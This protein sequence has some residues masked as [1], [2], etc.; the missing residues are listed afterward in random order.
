MNV[1][2][3]IEPDTGPATPVGLTTATARTLLAPLEGTG[4]RA[5]LV[6]GRLGTA[7]RLGLLIDGERLPSE[8]Q[9]AAQLGVSTVTLREA[10]STLRE[11]G[12]VVTRRGRSGGTFVQAPA[13]PGEPIGRFSVHDLQDLGDQ[14]R[15]IAGM[16]ARLAAERAQPEEVLRIAEQVK[17]L[18]AAETASDRRRADTQLAI[19]IAAAAQSPRLTHEEARLRAEIGDLLGLAIDRRDHE[20]AVRE[21]SRLVDALRDR[22]PE[23]ARELAE[24][25]VEAETARLIDLRLQLWGPGRAGSGRRSADD[26]LG[27]V[28]E[29]LE[30]IFD[31]LA[32][33]GRQ[34]AAVIEAALPEPRLEDLEPLRP[35]IFALLDAHRDLVAGAG[36]VTAPGLLADA[37]RWLEWWSSAGE[38]APE[39]L[40]VNLDPRAPDFFDYTAP[41]WYAT[42]TRTLEPRMSGP[43]VDYSCTNRYAITLS[44]PVDSGKEMSGIAAADVLVTTIEK[45]V[46]PRLAALDRPVAVTNSDGR[47]IASNDPSCPAG[48][49]LDFDRPPEPP[50]GTSSPA[51]SWLLVD[52]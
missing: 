1:K 33:L 42:P 3:E 34:F 22:E 10:L 52:L 13:D 23:R 49:R 32:G 36:I 24:L 14:R 51:R 25:H 28:I 7:I 16:A 30:Q 4:G 17:R 27:D 48:H 12:L 50:G 46:L 6:A 18:A 20:I 29:E 40:R 37:P 15:A 19:E 2:R 31:E 21:R 11:Q 9:L 39:P 35:T 26:V 43:F 45:R 38:G 5:E 44:S 47:V 8:S 41:E